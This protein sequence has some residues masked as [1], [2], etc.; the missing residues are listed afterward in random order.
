M[1]KSFCIYVMN[2]CKLDAAQQLHKS[3]KGAG[4]M[5]GQQARAFK[6]AQT[7]ASTDASEDRNSKCSCKQAVLKMCYDT[8][9]SAHTSDIA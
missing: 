2:K 6:S 8:L 5:K 9:C 3:M 4:P 1:R 7:N